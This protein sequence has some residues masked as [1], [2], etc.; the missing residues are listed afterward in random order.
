MKRVYF[1]SFI[2]SQLLFFGCTNETV[3]KNVA[4]VP[5]VRA[6]SGEIN[7]TLLFRGHTKY[8]QIMRFD[9]NVI[10]YLSEQRNPLADE[11]LLVMDVQRQ[12]ADNTLRT[13]S[14]NT[15]LSFT[16]NGVDAQEIRNQRGTQNLKSMRAGGNPLFGN[17]VTFSLSHANSEDDANN[18][19]RSGNTDT[20]REVT[21]YV[22]ELVQILSPRVET[23]QDLFPYVFYRNFI[24]KWNADPQNENGLVVIVEW[25]GNDMFGKNHGRAVT[26][27]DIITNDNG[28]TILDNRLF[29]DIPQG[30]I[31]RL[32]LIRGN[33]EII[34][35]FIN[36]Y[37]VAEAYRVVAASQAVLPFIMVREITIIDG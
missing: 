37:G 1:I 6:F 16:I 27:A 7:A 28:R 21:M 13:Q 10:G 24:L 4:N 34:E 14:I 30:A 25:D 32:I 2:A 31:A 20:S 15:N 35:N 17:T 11:R 22:P 18:M 12:V 26:S 3:E 8:A 19:L 5:A 9:A 29:E 36:E 33:I 23:A